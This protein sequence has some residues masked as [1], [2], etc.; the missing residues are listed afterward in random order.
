MKILLNKVLIVATLICAALSGIFTSCVEPQTT[1]VPKLEVAVSDTKQTSAEISIL[2]ENI[3]SIA[4]VVEK[5]ALESPLPAVIY[6][7]GTTLEPKK[8]DKIVLTDLQAET[9]YFVYFAARTTSGEF[10]DKTPVVPFTTKPYEFTELV[11]LLETY[12]DGFKIHLAMPESVRKNENNAIR[13]GTTSLAYYIL[14]KNMGKLDFDA[15]HTNGQM[16]TRNDTT[17][18]YNG[19]NI[20]LCDENGDPILDSYGQETYLHDPIAPGEPTVFFA[21]EFEK[22]ESHYGFGM[23]YYGALFDLGSYLE[24]EGGKSPYDIDLTWSTNEDKYWTGA[25]QRKVFVTKEPDLLEAKMNASIVDVSPINATLKLT[26]DKEVQQFSIAVC[27]HGTYKQ[28]LN[29]LDGKE[30]YLQW[31]TSSYLAMMEVGALTMQR[32][33]KDAEGN[34]IDEIVFNMTDFFYDYLPSETTFHIFITGMGNLQGTSQMFEHL[35]FETKAKTKPAPVIN[36]TAVENGQNEFEAKFLVKAPNKDV[37]AAYYGCNYARDW[38]LSLNN[39]STYADLVG[40]NY[41]FT[42]DG[43]KQI[44][45][46]EGLLMSFPSVD[47]QTTRLVVLGYNDEMRPNI[48]EKGCS[49][50]ADCKTKPQVLEPI[51]DSTFMIALEGDWTATAKIRIREYQNNNL[52][53]REENYT[54]KV[55]LSRRYTDYPA[56]LPNDVYDLYTKNTKEEVDGMY[57]DFKTEAY[58]FNRRRLVYRNRILCS[59]FIDYDFADYNRLMFQSPYDCFVSPEYSSVDVAS[60]FFDFG[61]K[62]YLDIDK[63]KDGNIVVT[64]P[65]DSNFLPPMTNARGMTYYLTAYDAETNNGYTSREDGKAAFPVEVSADKQ[66][67]TIKPLVMEDGTKLY[68]NAVGVGGTGTTLAAPVLS[69]IVLTKGW[70]GPKN[71]TKLSSAQKLSPIMHGV[72]PAQLKMVRKSMTKLNETKVLKSEI[73]VINEKVL[74]EGMEKMAEKHF[75]NKK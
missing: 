41:G 60:I 56:K 13:F 58:Y 10:Y 50:I 26:P 52:V 61:P 73:K 62:W 8:E 24:A 75:N 28:I 34:T 9:D 70:N 45:S 32:P 25:F 42:A 65:F 59:G 33:F 68:P 15:L 47:D 44:N 2:A 37:F 51:V 39:G 7:S 66:T 20:L 18:V 40:V 21:G 54:S 3:Q 36:V 35:T 29:M 17:L 19:D 14:L 46:D 11:N 57:E 27:D 1:V 23:G 49:A 72:E 63:D 71:Q 30:E 48:L 53:T 12:Y 38:Q 5:E 22:A 6:M 43:I 74:N 69:E 16:C 31:F 64:A 55:N 67:I 4:Y